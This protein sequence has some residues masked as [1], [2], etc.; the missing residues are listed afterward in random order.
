M[1][2]KQVLRKF[3]PEKKYAAFPSM[4]VDDA[5]LDGEYEGD[6][7]VLRLKCEYIC[8]RPSAPHDA[9][10]DEAKTGTGFLAEL[11]GK[12]YIVTAHHVVSDATL[13]TATTQHMRNGE[14]MRCHVIAQNPYIDVA[15]LSCDEDDVMDQKPFQIAAS[16]RLRPNMRI[17][18]VGFAG[19]SIRTHTTVGVISGRHDYPHNRI[20]TDAT[21][22][23]GNSG[24]PCLDEHGNCVGVCTSGMN[25]MQN[26]NFFVG[27]DEVMQMIARLSAR[28]NARLGQALD[29]GFHLPAMVSPVNE[30]ACLGKPGGMMVVRAAANRGLGRGD[31]IVACECD[32]SM[33]PLNAFG[34]VRCPQIYEDDTID[35]RTIL[36][37]VD[38]REVVF[39][40][41]LRVR[42]AKGRVE[43][44]HVPCG[45][46]VFPSRTRYPDMEPVEY[47]QHGG[48]IFQTL[49]ES[50]AK[51]FNGFSSNI[52]TDPDMTV[53]GCVVITYQLAGSP[54]GR[55]DAHELTSKIL[56]S[57]VCADGREV[58]T[59]TLEQLA[60]LVSSP[61][62]P[63]VLKLKT[64]ECVGANR[65]SLD[66]FERSR[67]ATTQRG[68]H[69]A[70]RG[71]L[72]DL[73][74]RA[75]A[76]REER[77]REEGARD[78]RATRDEKERVKIVAMGNEFYLLDRLLNS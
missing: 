65:E 53:D 29:F 60:G 24:G 57:V 8:Y 23:G 28:W 50:L 3:P 19:G 35:F 32:G 17:V 6:A 58:K 12:R 61:S 10:C 20:Q 39:H 42:R 40:W 16:N 69:V 41:K 55:H 67:D 38:E 4:R 64:G 62:L 44:I 51:E 31:V 26:T 73:Q 2:Q 18:V 43:T 66:E 78:E 11:N 54:F 59:R 45:P 15:I 70:V 1:F 71:G 30:Q 5:A 49:T 21:V 47:C 76:A 36:D 56:E 7:L 33:L 72:R 46:P 34:K 68:L 48:L 77:A 14:P 75:E 63:L 37:L 27:M 13:V 9:N 74:T 25:F 22:N 52:L